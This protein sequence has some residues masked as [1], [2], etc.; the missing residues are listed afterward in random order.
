[1][2]V[3]QVTRGE[4]GDGAEETEWRVVETVSYKTPVHRLRY[5]ESPSRTGAERLHLNAQ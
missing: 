4:T 5:P 2:S 3:T 1:M